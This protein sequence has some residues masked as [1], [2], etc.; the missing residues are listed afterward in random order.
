M[1]FFNNLKSLPTSLS[2]PSTLK[3][4]IKI[5]YFFSTKLTL[6]L[7]SKLFTTPISFKTPKR[8][9][10]MEETSQKKELFIPSIYRNIHILSYGFSDKKV[11]L[12]HGWSGRRTQL[13]MIANKLLENGYMTIS[14]DAPA[15]GKSTGKTTNLLEYIEAIKAIQKEYGPFEAAVGH[16]FGSMAIMNTQSE[17]QCFNKIVTIGSGDTTSQ[18]LRNFSINLGLNESFGNK[19]IIYFEKKWHLKV[20][21]YATSKVAKNIKIPA[22]I[23]HD[24]I[25]GDVHVSCAINIRQNLEKGTLFVTNGL[26]HIK[27]L[28][29]KIVTNKIVDFIKQ[30]I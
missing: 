26:G 7:A 3:I 14:F 12:A 20:D 23:V 28:R 21:D 1:H 19:L 24:T 18:I 29:N 30:D 11:L 17:T 5:L 22:L 13:F 4:A 6:I 10:G 2:I 25:D 16:S 8:E 15:H 9:K 27:I